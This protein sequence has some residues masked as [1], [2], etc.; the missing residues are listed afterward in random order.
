VVQ[1][2]KEEINI[3]LLEIYVIVHAILNGIPY[4]IIELIGKFIMPIQIKFGKPN[5]LS[6]K[7]K[8]QVITLLGD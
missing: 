5:G 6:R 7:D 1:E 4:I 2:P 8:N 3:G